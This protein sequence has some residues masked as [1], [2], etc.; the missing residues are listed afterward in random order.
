MTPQ[1]GR[2]WTII[3]TLLIKVKEENE[4]VGLKLNIQKT[5]TMASGPNS[6]RQM[7]GETMETV[8]DFSFGGSKITEDGD[9]SHEIERPLL[10]GRKAMTN[11]DSILKSRHYVANKGLSS[12]SNGF[13]SSH[14]W[15]WELDYKE[16]WAPKNWCFWTVVLEKTLESPLSARRSNHSI[17][18][19]ISPEYS[20][21]GLML[22]LW[23][24]G[25]LMQRA[26]S[27]EKI[28][29]VGK[30]ESGRTRGW[31]RMRWLDGITNLMGVSL[32][33]LREFIMDKEPGILQSRGSETTKWLN[34][35]ELKVEWDRRHS[36]TYTLHNPTYI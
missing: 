27:F 9:C 17:L 5:H 30:N 26:D 28:L 34:W 33:K 4:K 22:K 18:K 31:Q 11:L 7:D 3:K 21:E 12:K 24:F 20:V 25:H 8:T 32:S 29:M 16:R 6:S 23:Y 13:S 15:M 19:K 10:L 14:V 35:T 2:K 36:K 1:Y